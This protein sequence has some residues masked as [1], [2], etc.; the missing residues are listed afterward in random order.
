MKCL[1]DLSIKI[2]NS[3][4]VCIPEIASA[5]L[6]SESSIGPG[7]SWLD[8]YRFNDHAFSPPSNYVQITETS[9]D[10]WPGFFIAL[11]GNAT[12][13]SWVVDNNPGPGWGLWTV[14]VAGKNWT[15]GALVGKHVEIWSGTGMGITGSI[16]SNTAN[17]FS[18]RT[19]TATGAPDATT[20]Y[21]IIY[22]WAPTPG[23]GD[24]FAQLCFN[25]PLTD[26]WHL[27]ASTQSAGDTGN[28]SV[29][30]C[31]C[32]SD[33]S[34]NP[35]A[36]TMQT[37]TVVGQTIDFTSAINGLFDQVDWDF[38]DGTT[39]TNQTNTSHAY[40]FRK[41]VI[42]WSYDRMCHLYEVKQNVRSGPCNIIVPKDRFVIPHARYRIV[43]FTDS[44][45]GATGWN[46]AGHCDSFDISDWDG[47]MPVYWNDVSV[48]PPT[49]CRWVNYDWNNPGIP[50][51]ATI[52]PIND[53]NTPG[54]VLS[55]GTLTVDVWV[56]YKY[57]NV[58][59]DDRAD[60]VYNI[61]VPHNPCY[62]TQNPPDQVEVEAY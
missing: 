32:C 22:T 20:F 19:N 62:A 17:S 12:S 21:V 50:V 36:D 23:I 42:P 1:K 14:I 48:F 30:Y 58:G 7:F 9:D 45:F 37:P 54:Y 3:G 43:G 57:F 60:G 28:Y 55:I 40:G 6:T 52:M 27:F 29:Q 25:V 49:Y 34:S 59:D 18:V 11:N 53:T 10:F 46:T 61:E 47:T 16:V 39:E 56:G 35:S 44:M 33:W 13:G 5:S 24:N 2:D 41:I 51:F 31:C 4:V 38:D 15:V 26:E 8:G